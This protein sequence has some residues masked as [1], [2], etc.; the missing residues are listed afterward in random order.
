[1]SNRRNM[2]QRPP[3]GKCLRP[4]TRDSLVRLSAAPWPRRIICFLIAASAGFVLTGAAQT[5]N[6]PDPELQAAVRA[7]LAKPTGDIT[8]ADMESLTT[9][10]A[11]GLGTRNFEGIGA[12][13]NLTA[14]TLVGCSSATDPS[15]T[16]NFL[17]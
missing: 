2:I 9:L 5:V 13:K 1:Q 8:E 6:I 7:A 12:A 17:T 4:E 16:C 11:E 15:V 3:D 10:F 14:L